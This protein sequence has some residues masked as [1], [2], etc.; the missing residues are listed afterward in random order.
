MSLYWLLFLR[1]KDPLE[2]ALKLTNFADALFSMGLTQKAVFGLFS[3][4]NSRLYDGVFGVMLGLGVMGIG[5][6]VLRLSYLSR[7][8]GKDDIYV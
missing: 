3:L 1:G 8:N 5:G 2:L 6:Y 7:G 4:V